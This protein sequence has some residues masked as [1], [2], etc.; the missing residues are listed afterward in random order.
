MAR[1]AT[2]WYSSQNC[3]GQW[4]STDERR[5]I[6]ASTT[7]VAAVMAAIRQRIAGRSLTPGAKLPSVRA[8]AATMKLSTSTVVEAYE[9]LVAEG[10]ILSRPGSGFYVANQAAPFA[11]S[12]V[13]PR[14][15]RE[16][17]PFWVSRQ[18]LEAGDI[19]LKPGCGWLPP[20]WL[21]EDGVRRGR[22]IAV[23]GRRAG[24]AG[25]R[26]AARPAAAAPADRAADGRQGDRR[27]AGPDH[28]D[29]VRDT[30]DRPALPVPDRAG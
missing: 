29:R 5:Q 10:A 30:G 14:L 12:E 1:P 24:A 13:G 9:R 7:R 11:L 16:V 15:D 2:V 8:L 17:D 3:Y 6:P 4:G 28:P 25:L 27:L 20:A 19:G 23:A 26:L 22:A 21:P 18:S